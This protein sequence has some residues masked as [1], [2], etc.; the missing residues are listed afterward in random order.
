VLASVGKKKRAYLGRFERI[1][2]G[3]VNIK[4]KDTSRVGRACIWE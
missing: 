1:V 3:E 4:E 2:C